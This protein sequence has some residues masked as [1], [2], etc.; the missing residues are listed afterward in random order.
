M[1]HLTTQGNIMLKEAVHIL[2]NENELRHLESHITGFLLMPAKAGIRKHGDKAAEALLKDF[3][4]LNDEDTFEVTNP[5]NLTK[6][7]NKKDLKALSI[8]TEKRDESSKGRTCADGRKQRQWK[9]KVEHA[10]PA[11]RADSALLASVAYACEERFV[12]ISDIKGACFNA[13]FDEFLLKKIE[14]EQANA[15]CDMDTKHEK[16]V[17]IENRK[18]VLHLVLNKALH[19]CVKIVLS[20]C[21]LF[22]S[23]S[24]DMLFV[25]SPNDSCV[26]SKDIDGSQCTIE[27][28]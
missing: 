16:H 7:Q 3:V 14:N 4:Q 15:M 28:H 12:G 19:G 13:K 25:L 26:A 27:W 2:K 1:L 23:C 8:I 9:S 18:R 24:I 10:S 6:S 22:P 20:W 5:N 11:T 21:T 17:V